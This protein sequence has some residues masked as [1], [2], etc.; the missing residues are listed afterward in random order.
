MLTMFESSCSG[1][2]AVPSS[3]ERTVSELAI[4]LLSEEWPLSV[5]GLMHRMKR[6]YAREV[7]FQAAHKA[8]SK[9]CRHEI[10]LKT[11]RYYKINPGWL[12]KMEKYASSVN[13][14]YAAAEVRLE[15]MP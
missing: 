5:K 6:R 11:G 12:G 1:T 2:I 9:L 8:V 15:G 3:G 10:L 7:T 14:R 4:A 13:S